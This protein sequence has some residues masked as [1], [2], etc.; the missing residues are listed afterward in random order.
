MMFLD[1]R[2][3]LKK[4][5]ARFRMH[6]RMILL[7]SSIKWGDQVSKDILHVVQRLN[8]MTE[9]PLLIMPQILIL[10]ISFY[11]MVIFP[12]TIWPTAQSLCQVV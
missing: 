4:T 9:N 8:N 3:I 6:P 1:W 12:L 11:L 10:F 5:G 2:K 7:F